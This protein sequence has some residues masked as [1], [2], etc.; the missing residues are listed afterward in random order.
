[1]KSKALE[2]ARNLRCQCTFYK[3]T[4]QN[5]RIFLRFVTC[6]TYGV[7]ASGASVA[8]TSQISPS[9]ILLL[10]IEEKNKYGTQVHQ[11]PQNH[12]DKQDQTEWP[13]RHACE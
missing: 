5:F 10:V 13:D 3:T 2:N 11:L 7:K 8:S 1:M 4:H 12:C 6:V 9:T